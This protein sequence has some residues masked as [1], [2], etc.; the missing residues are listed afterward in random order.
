MQS[1]VW[2]VC[3]PAERESI[4]SQPMPQNHGYIL[5]I[6]H[7]AVVEL[8]QRWRRFPVMLWEEKNGADM[9]GYGTPIF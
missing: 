3:T 5:S 8:C 2:Q 1:G 9:L 4:C 6:E 7:S